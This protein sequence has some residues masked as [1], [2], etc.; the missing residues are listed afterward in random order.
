[1]GVIPLREVAIVNGRMRSLKHMSW[2]RQAHGSKV[3][4]VNG[5]MRSLKLAPARVVFEHILRLR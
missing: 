3:A 1:M 2:A 5:R 4:I